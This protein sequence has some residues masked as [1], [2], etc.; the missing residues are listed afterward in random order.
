MSKFSKFISKWGPGG[1]RRSLERKRMRRLMRQQMPQ[2]AAS[3]LPPPPN[4]RRVH[5]VDEL[6]RQ[7]FPDCD[8]LRVYKV[9]GAQRP[10]VTIVTDNINAGSLYGGVGTALMLGALLAENCGASLRIVTRHEA[11]HTDNLQHILRIAGIALSHEPQF[12]LAPPLR[13][14]ARVDVME[15]E[16]FLTTSWWTTAAVLGTVPDRQI[17]YLLQEDERM[18]YSFGDQRLYCEQTISNSNIRFAINS[19]LMYEHLIEDGFSNIA[20][21]GVYFEPAFPPEIFHRRHHQGKR[22]FMFYAR[23]RGH[24]RNLFYFGLQVMREVVERGLLP[25]DE[26]E[27]MFVGKEVP[28]LTL[29]GETP[30][31]A[32]EGMSWS[33]YAEFIGTIDVALSLMYTPHPSYPPLD[34]AASGAVVVTN[35]FGNKTS[36]QRYSDSILTAPLEIGALANAVAAAVQQAAQ[37]KEHDETRSPRLGRDWKIQLKPVVDSMVVQ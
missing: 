36:L 13:D 1:F 21:N 4:P 14:D 6:I 5:G 30:I 28:R 2:G 34:L 32:V 35:Q 15:D 3:S 17:L 37:R 26:W 24:D 23:P 12:L 22:R 7:R 20:R 16:L 25:S 18:F 11:A 8:K 9:P 19:Q 31:T 33:Q 10:R 29:D 27:I